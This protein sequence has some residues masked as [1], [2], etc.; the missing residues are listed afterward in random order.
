C[1]LRKILLYHNYYILPYV[2]VTL[3]NIVLSRQV[4]CSVSLSR[5]IPC[6]FKCTL[7]TYV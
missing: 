1:S 2:P 4:V 7:I 6:L 5:N 3:S